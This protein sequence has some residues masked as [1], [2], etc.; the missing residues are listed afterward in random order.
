FFHINNN[1]ELTINDFMKFFEGFRSGIRIGDQEKF[2]ET[3][4]SILDILVKYEYIE[5]LDIQYDRDPLKRVF[6]RKEQ[7]NI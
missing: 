7:L 2:I 6:I 3:V 5:E 4:S 1:Q